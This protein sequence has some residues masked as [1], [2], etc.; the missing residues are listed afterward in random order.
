M[1]PAPPSFD[2]ELFEFLRQLR[3]H[4]R[5][6]WFQS[7]KERYEEHVKH[8]A[9]QFISDFGPRLR[10]ISPEFVADPR[11]AGGSL[12]RIYRDVRFSKDKS[13]YKTSVGIQFRHKQAKDV[14]APGFYLHLEPD[15]C[16]MGLGIWHP[17]GPT[18]NRIRQSL[19]EHPTRWK[20]V[21]GGKRLSQSFKLGGE[22]LKRAPRGYDPEHPLIEDLK[23]KDFIAVTELTE[24]AVTSPGFLDVY[25]QLCKD[26]SPLVRFLCEA[27][28]VPF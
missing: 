14:H 20:R 27:I 17:D 8:P 1:S 6:N 13:P 21:I 2:E 23:R 3:S 19:A 16:F 28:G 4:N 22:S 5:R 18:L 15:S 26:G 25:A 12:F 9:L 11:P 24:S 10:Q 7:N